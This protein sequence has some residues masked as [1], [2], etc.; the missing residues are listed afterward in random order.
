MIM[1]VIFLI[2]RRY[3]GVKL[4]VPSGRNNLYACV[5]VCVFPRF[6]RGE[7]ETSLVEG[8]SNGHGWS[9]GIKTEKNGRKLSRGKGRG[10][11]KKE[12]KEKSAKSGIVGSR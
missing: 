8:Q 1:L 7:A 3:R 9:S 4:L 11:G 2:V 12:R 5:R 10:E 6:L